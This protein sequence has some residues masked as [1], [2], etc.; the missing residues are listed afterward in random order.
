MNTLAL[1]HAP[2]FY[3]IHMQGI[4]LI[5]LRLCEN[6]KFVYIVVFLVAKSFVYKVY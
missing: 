5:F 3:C 1:L 6:S 2:Y 4:H